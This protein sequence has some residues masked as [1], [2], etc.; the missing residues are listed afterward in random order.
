MAPKQSNSPNMFT[1]PCSNLDGA[2]LLPSSHVD[3]PQIT[4]ICERVEATCNTCSRTLWKQSNV[5]GTTLSLSY[6]LGKVPE[7]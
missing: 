1:Q 4:E 2:A 6:P 7:H 5:C 3:F